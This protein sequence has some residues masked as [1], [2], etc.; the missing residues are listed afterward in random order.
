[1]KRRNFTQSLIAA[2]GVSSIPV[3]VSLAVSKTESDL[4]KENMIT[5]ADGLKLKLDSKIHPV[6]NQDE[7]Q[8]I[9]TY[10]VEN[11]QGQLEEKIYDLKS[12]E[13]KN[14]QVFMTPI[15][16]TQLQAV[17]NRRLNA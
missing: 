1:M 10:S 3:G 16:E 9:L 11:L 6:N 8:F 14:Y 17:F 5:S 15:N 2:L 13:G 7:K 12:S 4:I